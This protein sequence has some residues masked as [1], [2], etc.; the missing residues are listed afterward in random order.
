MSK[1]Y[2]TVILENG[3]AI[4][5]DI[6]QVFGV[7]FILICTNFKPL[8]HKPLTDS[9]WLSIEG[10]SRMDSVGMYDD[11]T[12]YVIYQLQKGYHTQ[13]LLNDIETKFKTYFNGTI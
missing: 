6:K 11:N 13:N 4:R 8:E 12:G 10:I 3:K 9:E 1:L 5:Y 2:K 7:H